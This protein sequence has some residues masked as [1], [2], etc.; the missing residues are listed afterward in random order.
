MKIKLPEIKKK[1]KPEETDAGVISFGLYD[2][3]ADSFE[4]NV[5]NDEP[6]MKRTEEE[7]ETG[8]K[9][10][11]ALNLSGAF[12]LMAA[13][14]VF[15]SASYAIGMIPFAAAGMIVYLAITMSESVK[16]GRLRWIIAGVT[17]VILVAAIVVFHSRIG[18]G[19]ALLSGYFYD[20][21]EM[22]Q[23]YLYNRFPVSDAASASPDMCA[24]LA[25]IWI[26]CLGGLITALPTADYRRG[27][28]AFTAGLVMLAFAYYGIIPSWICIGVILI[29]GIIASSKGSLLSSLPVLLIAALLF[30]AIVLLDPGQNYFVSRANENIRDIFALKSS[31]IENPEDPLN[32]LSELQKE[33]Q[34]QQEKQQQE[35]DSVTRRVFRSAGIAFLILAAI[36]TAAVL[37]WR[38]L[39]QRIEKN[40]EGIDADDPAEAIAAMFPYCVRWLESYGIEAA[41][42]P[43]S[44]ITED[45]RDEMTREY[46]YR[47][48]DMYALWQEAAYS[49]HEM[50]LN[51]KK[52][53]SA[54]MHDTI[55][56][57]REK[58]D[59][60]DKV[61]TRIRYAL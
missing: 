16:P 3:P 52:Q 20:T 4:V 23:A 35:E 44:S 22:A 18:G 12:I 11:L 6:I 25:T 51:Q 49:E 28:C 7:A 13:I 14:S 58:S 15:L 8:W 41:G 24:R 37:Y 46:A 60:K 57:I 26:S 29:A 47:Y 53:M 48:E 39:K 54:F 61:L 40:R 19:L 50:T 43:F 31:F 42:R 32:D 30:G 59:F 2:S 38:K 17:A 1:N 5:R 9:K 10:D 34:E 33:E 45:I 55:E 27:M 36:G 21:A 56:M